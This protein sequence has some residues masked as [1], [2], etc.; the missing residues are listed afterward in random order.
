MEMVA[1]CGRGLSQLNKLV[2]SGTEAPGAACEFT[3]FSL[4]SWIPSGGRQLQAQM[5]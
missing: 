5:T 2:G 1:E 3:A 4:N